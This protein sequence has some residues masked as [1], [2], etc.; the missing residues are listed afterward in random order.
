MPLGEVTPVPL[1]EGR[2][3]T[4]M[5]DDDELRSYIWWLAGG[6]WPKRRLTGKDLKEWKRR[7]REGWKEGEK[8]GYLRELVFVLSRGKLCKKPK[9]S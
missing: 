4:K 5:Q 7:S 9:E 8:R 2:V 6:R 3:A 1:R